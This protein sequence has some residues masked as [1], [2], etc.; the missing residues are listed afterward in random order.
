[1]KK[2]TILDLYLELYCFDLKDIE[3]VEF[4]GYSMVSGLRYLP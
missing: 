1:M 4:D 3:L 2:S